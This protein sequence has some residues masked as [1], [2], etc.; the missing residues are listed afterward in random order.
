ML[1]RLFIFYYFPYSVYSVPSHAFIFYCVV[2]L[3]HVVNNITH[4][5]QSQ[6]QQQ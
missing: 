4:C 6:Q 3:L 5:W 2:K 1:Y